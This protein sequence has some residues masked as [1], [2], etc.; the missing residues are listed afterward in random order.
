MGERLHRGMHRCVAA[1]ARSG[2]DVVV[3][4]VLLERRWAWDLAD[5]LAGVLAVLVGVRCPPEVLAA[6][7][8][9]RADR[10]L[11]QAVAQHAAVHAHGG[12]D[13]EVDTS[14]QGPD[15]AADAVMA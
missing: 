8:R 12:Y 3:N 9:A 13:V 6:R 7:E 10:T 2:R 11:G 5:A 4:H 14:S 15:E 1:L